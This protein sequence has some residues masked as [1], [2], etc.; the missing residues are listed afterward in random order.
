MAW[1]KPNPVAS[2]GFPLREG[3]DEYTLKMAFA[4][5]VADDPANSMRAGYVLFDRG[6]E[7]YGRAMQAQTWLLDPVVNDRISKLVG[8]DNVSKLLPSDAEIEKELWDTIKAATDPSLK[9]KG[10]D[11]MAQIRGMKKTAGDGPGGGNTFIQNV[12]RLP[13]RVEGPQ[14]E[15]LFEARF[16]AQQLKLVRDARSPKPD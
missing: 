1:N 15:A 14:E 12:I 5:I 13:Q 4:E 3:E 16:E 2:T 10:I 9:V 7:D 8:K 11:L 6:P